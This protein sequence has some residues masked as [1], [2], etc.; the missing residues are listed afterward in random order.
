MKNKN[1]ISY[2]KNQIQDRIWEKEVIKLNEEELLE[3]YKDHIEKRI[4]NAIIINSE[5]DPKNRLIK[6]FPYRPAIYVEI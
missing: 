6:S 3:E 5:Y 2:I 1:L 4:N